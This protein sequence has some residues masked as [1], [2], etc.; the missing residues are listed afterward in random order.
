MGSDLWHSGLYRLWPGL[1]W[2]WILSQAFQA[3]GRTSYVFG[4]QPLSCWDYL[5]RNREKELDQEADAINKDSTR[6][7]GVKGQTSE[8]SVD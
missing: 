5:G 6:I 8:V 3:L 1:A 4:F 2:G 7:G